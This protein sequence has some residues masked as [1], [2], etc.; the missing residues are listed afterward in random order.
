M[1]ARIRGP[2]ANPLWQRLPGGS[3]GLL[4]AQG[5]QGGSEGSLGLSGFLR[6][7]VIAASVELNVY[8]VF[9]RKFQSLFVV[10]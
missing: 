1:G 10:F 6:E 2:V 8:A 4:R 7:I 3:W 5:V 9:L